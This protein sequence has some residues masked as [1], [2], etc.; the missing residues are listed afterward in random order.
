MIQWGHDKI[1][2][3]KARRDWKTLPPQFEAD[4]VR[5]TFNLIKPHFLPTSQ[6]IKQRIKASKAQTFEELEQAI[7]R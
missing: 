5:F 4:A 6:G 1:A 3:A 2:A 7:I